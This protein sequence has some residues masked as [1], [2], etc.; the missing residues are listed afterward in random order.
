M[1]SLNTPNWPIQCIYN[2]V[3]HCGV[4]K[5]DV[6]DYAVFLEGF[7]GQI[8]SIWVAVGV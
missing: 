4:C 6:A 7:L 2:L 3:K 8:K 5:N 1:K